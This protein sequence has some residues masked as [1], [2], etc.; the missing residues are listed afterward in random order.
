MRMRVGKGR[1]RGLD[2]YIKSSPQ[3]TGEDVFLS[4]RGVLP[5]SGHTECIGHKVLLCTEYANYESLDV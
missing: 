3:R 2:V 1:E 5:D 4:S